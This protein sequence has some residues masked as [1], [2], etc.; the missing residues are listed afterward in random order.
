MMCEM[1]NFWVVR[2]GGGEFAEICK[3]GKYVGI[4]WNE[5]GD[6]TWLSDP[7]TPAEDARTK[8]YELYE[9][10]GRKW[11]EN[12]KTIEVNRGQVYRFVREIKNGDYIL[13]PT[14]RRTVLVGNVTSDFY[15][16]K[17]KDDCPYKQRRH[18]DWLKEISRDDMSQ[19]L[20]NSLGAHLTV[21]KLTGHEDEL[22]ALIKG[23]KVTTKLEKRYAEKDKEESKVGPTINFRG[24]V[25]APTNEQG[26]IFLFSKVSKDL[27]IEIEEIRTGFPDAIG[28][29]QTSKG[30]YVRRTIEF[31]YLSSHYDHLPAK[32]DMIICWK[33]DWAECPPE[34]EVIALEGVVKE[35]SKQV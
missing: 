33:H 32:C 7:N 24:L 26:V 18:V 14:A 11:K 2:M 25:Y 19:R 21:F 10:W 30:Y 28:R 29:V 31:E 8:L 23:E 15:L 17:Q 35:L 1:A 12:K 9:K 27:N 3:K 16:S 20:R 5:L 34:I 22:H 6:L 13:S 4:G